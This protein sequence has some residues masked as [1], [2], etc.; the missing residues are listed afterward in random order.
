MFPL[1]SLYIITCLS[2]YTALHYN[3][4]VFEILFVNEYVSVLSPIFRINGYVIFSQ[5][6]YYLVHFL[7]KRNQKLFNKLKSNFL[8]LGSYAVVCDPN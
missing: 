1:N 3:Y 5:L 4:I 2:V 6:W 8:I 7:H